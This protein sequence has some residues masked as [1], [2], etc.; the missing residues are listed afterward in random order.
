MRHNPGGTE[1]AVD[2][3][4]YMRSCKHYILKHEMFVHDIDIYKSVP[5]NKKHLKRQRAFPHSIRVEYRGRGTSR[6]SARDVHG[7]MGSRARETIQGEASCLQA[8]RLSLPVHI[9]SR[10]CMYIL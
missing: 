3:L 9:Q 7:G 4:S 6:A 5:K 8:A 1:I 2:P 10:S